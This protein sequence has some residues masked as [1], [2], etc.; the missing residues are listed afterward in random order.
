MANGDQSLANFWTDLGH[1]SVFTSDE[2]Y[3]TYQVKGLGSAFLPKK[4]KAK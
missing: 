4:S 2:V 1:S 3:E